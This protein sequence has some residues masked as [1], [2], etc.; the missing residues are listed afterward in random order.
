[1]STLAPS[2]QSSSPTLLVMAAGMG[3]RFGGLKQVEPVGPCGETIIDYSVYDAL[4]AGFGRL[5]FVIKRS[6]E[7]DFRRLV[8]QR[9]EERIAVDYAFQE[10]DVALPAGFAPPADRVKPWGTG[11]AVLAAAGTVREPFAVINGD[12]F[13]GR[14]SFGLLG[15]RLR[16]FA[17]A[18]PAGQAGRYAMV[19]FTLRQTLSEHG[20]VARGVCSVGAGGH[21]EGIVERTGVEPNGQGGATCANGTGGRLPL[22]GDEIVSMNMWGFSPDVFAAFAQEFDTFLRERGGD[23]KA[24]FY[25]PTAVNNMMADGRARVEVLTSGDAWFGVTYREDKPMVDRAIRRL[26]AQ[27][28]YSENLWQ[29]A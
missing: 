12:D 15:A 20:A 25:L 16:E 6:I 1:M 14:E 26:V 19:G 29:S 17:G 28:V 23:A 13:Y 7:A 27:G 11:H 22:T 8:G 3:S 18:P 24:E 4:R 5:V 10:M 2:S 21:L 9:F